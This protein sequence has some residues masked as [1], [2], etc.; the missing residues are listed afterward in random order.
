MTTTRMPPAWID[1]LLR[2][3]VTPRRYGDV[4]GDLLEEYRET[5]LPALG[6][7]RAD[8]WYFRQILDFVWRAAAPWAA[9][10]SLAFVF[11]T[12][13]DWFVPMTDFHVRSAVSTYV[14][15]GILVTAG[16]VAGRR[17]GATSAGCVCGA[18]VA[19]LSA[20]FSLC[21]V[22]ALLIVRHDETTLM[23]IQQSGGLLEAVVLPLCALVPGAALGTI[24]GALGSFAAIDGLGPDREPLRVQPRGVP[25]DV[26]RWPDLL[27]AGLVTGAVFGAID[28]LMT[29]ARPLDDDSPCAL[30]RF[31]GPMFAVWVTVAFRE[32]RRSQRLVRGVTAATIV[33]FA[34]WCAFVGTNFVRVNLFLERLT[35]RPD[36]QDMMLRFQ[37]S[38]MDNLRQFVN[39]DYAKG[40]PFKI[41]AGTVIGA[42][43]GTVGA[44]LSRWPARRE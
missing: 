39:L 24:G 3:V 20:M 18:A 23:A 2:L 19:A 42:V 7:L 10:F 38:G 44:A 12:A 15:L 5:A 33:A 4:S 35:S 36:W 28:V 30:L 31:Y 21:G 6:G 14:A 8:M 37:A 16:F 17:V 27:L 22:A 11:R 41:A 26:M 29:W 32:A 34:T 13:L 9:L 40:T 1:H 43:M 25:G